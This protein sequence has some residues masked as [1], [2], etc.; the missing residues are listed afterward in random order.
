MILVVFFLQLVFIAPHALLVR[1]AAFLLHRDVNYRLPAF[2]P[3]AWLLLR[4]YDAP[5][6]PVFLARQLNCWTV[7]EPPKDTSTS[8]NNASASRAQDEEME[9]E[10]LAMRAEMRKSIVK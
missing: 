8:K 6:E 1:T 2:S 7:A 10:R 5:L 4:Y 9:R 3:K